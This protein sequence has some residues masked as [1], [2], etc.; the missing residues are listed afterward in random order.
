MRYVILKEGNWYV[1]RGRSSGKYG[2]A[3]GHHRT[4][5]EALEQKEA[6]NA[7]EKEKSCPT[8]S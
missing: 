8:P 6:L 2:L 1:V 4:K 7:A 3:Q 5:E